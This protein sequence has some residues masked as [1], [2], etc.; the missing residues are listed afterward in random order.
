M[1]KDGNVISHLQIKNQFNI[2]NAS[3]NIL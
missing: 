3:T 1:Y 2:T